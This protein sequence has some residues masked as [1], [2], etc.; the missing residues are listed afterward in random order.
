MKKYH[1]YQVLNEIVCSI[2]LPNLIQY[3]EEVTGIII[4]DFDVTNQLVIKHS[5]LVR[6]W[7]K[8]QSILHQ[9]FCRMVRHSGNTLGLYLGGAK[10]KLHLGDW[11]FLLRI[12]MVLLGSSR[13]ILG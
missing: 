11:L 1:C 7:R 9:L 4:E 3:A 2:L 10:L 5:T 12:F 8:V 13:Q 6:Y